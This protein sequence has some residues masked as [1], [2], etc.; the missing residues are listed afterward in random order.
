MP[1]QGRE[2][3][4]R[5]RSIKNSKKI[6]KAM[7]L[8]SAA[9]MRRAVQAALN[10][11]TYANMLW[12]IINRVMHT[13]E[14]QPADDVRRF[15][16]AP[17]LT[18][19]TPE[20]ITLLLFTSNRGLCGAFNS[21]VMKRVVKQ[22]KHHGRSNVELIAVGKK[23]VSTLNN[24]G[25]K[26]EFAY[27]KDDAAKSTASISE[28]ATYVY[29]QFRDGKTNRVLVA[30]TDYKSTVLQTPVVKQLFPLL[31]AGSIAEGVENE[32]DLPQV[33]TP[34]LPIN[35]DYIYEP[36]KLDVLEYVVPRL[37]EV[38]IYQALLESNASEHSARMLAMKN[39]TDAATDMI[40][41]LVLAFNRARQ[42]SIT[43]EIAEIAAGTAAVS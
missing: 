17:E 21:N 30:Y 4:N 19:G 39:A 16:I 27:V 32:T 6:T 20:R 22:L 13:I 35:A 14:L 11:R 26:A 24:I 3:K 41:D 25:V 43:K 31:Q 1:L 5:L 28:I 40:D 18:P 34:H 29:K 9:K 15:F 36:G 10:T 12:D 2:I 23:G 33:V 8:V 7:E 37:A 38:Q 42:A